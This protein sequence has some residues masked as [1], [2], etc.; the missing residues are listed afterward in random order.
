MSNDDSDRRNPTE[1][2]TDDHS[3]EPERDEF[4]TNG[5]RNGQPAQHGRE[6]VRRRPGGAGGQKSI[7]DILQEPDTKE[8]LKSITGTM[9]VAGLGLGLLVFV[10]G[11]FGGME[12]TRSGAQISDQQYK[13]SLVNSVF[14]M[15]PFLGFAIASVA[16]LVVGFEMDATD[17]KRL[18]TA[19]AGAFAGLVALVMVAEII[20]ST[21]TPSSAQLSLDYGQALINSVVLGIIAAVM[22]GGAAYFA[23]NLDA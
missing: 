5:P 2:P 10:L 17:R 13:L 9:A 15:A 22:S 8:W 21:Q 1:P 18:V 19:G 14:Q 3:T 7:G 12:L 23:T 6:E 20:A 11:A 4:G 16:G